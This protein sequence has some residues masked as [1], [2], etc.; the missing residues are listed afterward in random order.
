MTNSTSARRR[1]ATKFPTTRVAAPSVSSADDV[2]L[3]APESKPSPLELIKQEE[4]FV[5]D[6]RHVNFMIVCVI[7]PFVFVSFFVVRFYRMKYMYT[8][9]SIVK[10]HR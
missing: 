7:L 3:K 1:H 8:R 10:T 6:V 4:V 9:T 2:P 5:G